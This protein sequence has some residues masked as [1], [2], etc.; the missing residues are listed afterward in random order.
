VTELIG[1][2][3]RAES[4]FVQPS[5]DGLAERVRGNPGLRSLSAAN[6]PDAGAQQNDAVAL[7]LE[8][9]AL[10]HAHRERRK[11]HDAPA[12]RQHPVD[13][14]DQVSSTA[15]VLDARVDFAALAPL[16]PAIADRARLTTPGVTSCDCRLD[17]SVLTARSAAAR[18]RPVLDTNR[19]RPS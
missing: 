10:E 2:L 5:R 8:A 12:R 13:Y 9:A 17:N 14:I 6:P 15:R 19:V 11:R 4:G 7:E 18:E 16:L 3:S 1:D